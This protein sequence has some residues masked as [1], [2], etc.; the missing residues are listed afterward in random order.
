[1]SADPAE[2]YKWYL[3]AGAQ[4]ELNARTNTIRLEESLTQSQRTEGQKRASEFRPALADARAKRP[5]PQVTKQSRASPREAASAP[6]PSAQGGS[7]ESSETLEMCRKAAEA[8]DSDAQCRLGGRYASGVGVSVDEGEAIK[9][10][11]RAAEQGNPTGQYLMGM[12]FAFGKG[13]AKDH[14]EALKWLRHAADQGLAESQFELGHRYFSGVG[15]AKN[16][17]QGAL[18]LRK[19]AEQGLTRAQVRLAATLDRKPGTEADSVEALQWFRKAAE[20]GDPQG[21]FYLCLL[22]MEGRSTVKDF[23]E[24]FKWLLLSEPRLPNTPETN[25]IVAE[26]KR[27]LDSSM[28]PAQ[29][30]EGRHRASTFK[31][32]VQLLSV[33]PK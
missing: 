6:K 32:T 16:E 30:E 5:S 4:G 14:V 23:S 11:R 15:V 28:T 18:W 13:V 26:A 27:K 22:Y 24:A 21:Q 20:A 19:A 31:P 7:E 17:A 9:W 2:A 10:F 1:M 12:A 3:L 25:L 33:Q 8:G 29:K